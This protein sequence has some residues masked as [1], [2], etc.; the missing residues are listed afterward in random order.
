M[1]HSYGGFFVMESI[2][3]LAES[4]DS[5]GGITRCLVMSGAM[6]V[7]IQNLRLNYLARFFEL[8][9]STTD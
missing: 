3:G 1:G 2:Q 5:A 9:F 4:N 8:Q 7:S 6:S